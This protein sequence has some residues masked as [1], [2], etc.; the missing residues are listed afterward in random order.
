MVSLLIDVAILA[1]GFAVLVKAADLL[2]EGS[3]GLS[4]RFGI[5]ELVIGLT[6]CA[7]GTSAPEL[8]VNG[9]AALQGR[10]DLVVGNVLGSNLFN[11]LV[12]L[13]VGSLITTLTIQPRAFRTELLFGTVAALGTL[14]LAND[15][16][17]GPAESVLSRGDAGLLLL[18]FA[19]FLRHAMSIDGDEDEGG[20]EPSESALKSSGVLLVGAAGLPLGAHLVVMSSTDIASAV[21]VSEG[22]IGL[23]LVSMGTSL[24]ELAATAVAARKGYIG[25]AVGNVL[26]SN[27]FNLLL[28]L[29]ASSALNPIAFDAAFNADLAIL[30]GAGALV[31]V[32]AF[33]PKEP[34]LTRA[35]GFV[36]LAV[37]ALYVVFLAVR[38]TGRLEADEVGGRVGSAA[39]GPVGWG[40]PERVASAADTRIHSRPA[41]GPWR[42]QR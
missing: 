7:F 14:V 17:F 23:T 31:Y 37:F 18:G 4:R 26:G 25:L 38:E 8:F 42:P 32:L 2:V 16:W 24:P 34:G 5:P 40:P 3:I 41:P 9:V 20:S 33:R 6:I 36:L 39:P 15:G 11:T 13:G 35:A 27:V 12:V 1:A 22:L 30:V 28:V 10:D 21:G 29:G 19:I